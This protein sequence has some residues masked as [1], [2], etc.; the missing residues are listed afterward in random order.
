MAER[1]AVGAL[2]T[3][4]ELTRLG[5]GFDRAWPVDET[6]C[7]EGLLLAIDEA[8]RKLRHDADEQRNDIGPQR[9]PRR[10]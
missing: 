1:I 4:S 10:D 3:A 6:P 7:F 8:D 2:L 5:M 9:I